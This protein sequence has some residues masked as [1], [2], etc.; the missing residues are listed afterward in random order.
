MSMNVEIQ[1]LLWLHPDTASVSGDTSP[2]ILPSLGHSKSIVRWMA[3][4]GSLHRG[5]LRYAAL[6]AKTSQSCSFHSLVLMQILGA[7]VYTRLNRL[8]VQLL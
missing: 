4:G 1:V 8:P 3:G 2:L 5:Y 7:T 6:R